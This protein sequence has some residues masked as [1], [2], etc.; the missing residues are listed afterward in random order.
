MEGVRF[1]RDRHGTPGV[2]AASELGLFWGLGVLHGRHRPLQALLLP[3]AGRGE[4]SSLLAPR[5]EL[6]ALD[7]L[8]HRLDLGGRG[9]REAERLSEWARAR[10][11]AYL[12]GLASGVAEAGVPLELRL[13]AARLPVPDRAAL[14]SGFLLS[15]YLGLAE[16]QERM[17]RALV[18][19][20][21]QGAD[22]AVLGLMFAPHLD[23][24]SPEV[25]AGVRRA[26]PLGFA[27]RAFAAVGGSN[28]WAVSPARSA[29][30][31]ALLAGDPHLEVGQLPALF[32]EVRLQLGD[33]WWIGASIPGLPG[34]AVGRSRRVAWSGTFAVADNVDL[35]VEELAGGRTRE[36]EGWQAVTRREVEVRRRGRAPLR[37]SFLET[38]RGVLESDGSTEGR[39]LAVGWSS[40]EGAAEAL[41]AYLRLMFAES[42]A[43]A[44]AVLDGGHTLSLHFVLADR[45]GDVRYRQQGRI[46]RRTGG[47]S[48]LHPVLA[49]GER[50]WAGVYAG[51]ALPRGPAEDGL[52]ATANEARPAPD[53]A[54][55]STLAQPEYRLARIRA[56]LAAR[57]DHDPASFRAMQSDLYSLQAERL[58]PVLLPAVPPGPMADALAAWDLRCDAESVGAFAFDAVRRAA[59]SALAPELGGA[60]METML[61]ESELGLWWA[62]ALDRLLAA[63]GTWTSA[64]RQR[65][66]EALAFAARAVPSRWGEA[67]T[68]T[69]R[70]LVLGG[71]PSFFGFDRGPFPLPGSPATVCQGTALSLGGRPAVVAPA[72]RFV[73]DLGDDGAYASLPGGV[74]GARFDASYDLWLEDHLA[75]RY[76]RIEPPARD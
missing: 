60:W 68:F 72:Y 48:G 9:R 40:G 11:D 28:A 19:A 14:L 70:H 3:A 73:T 22:P 5:A 44:E 1:T 29:S 45:G 56:L 32:F 12:E 20:L 41:E 7:A 57:R 15:S 33:D 10:L 16:G 8:A 65:L 52:V 27:S 75:F 54:V 47:W 39:Q 21:E 66:G 38:P 46:P 51:A 23:G 4:L 30:G 6:V 35:F 13:L 76:H 64:R 18:E 31:H 61:Q 2:L 74:D 36:R 63:P 59:L 58:L 37:L 71:L 34:I 69:L 67:Q 53:G 25:L 42:A 43:E 49:W 24:F 50:G 55:L 17:E 62:R 26:R